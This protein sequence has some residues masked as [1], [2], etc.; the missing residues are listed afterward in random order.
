MIEGSILL[1]ALVAAYLMLL[2]ARGIERGRG[3]KFLTALF[4]FK[5]TMAAAKVQ[6][7]KGKHRA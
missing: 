7:S 2:H 3:S 1:F 4:D 6:I 5:E